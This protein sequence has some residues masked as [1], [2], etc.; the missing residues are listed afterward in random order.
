MKD[1]RR[2]RAREPQVKLGRA[3]KSKYARK[4]LPYG[5]EAETPKSSAGGVVSTEGEA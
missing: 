4:T 1:S 5:D 3:P 2:N